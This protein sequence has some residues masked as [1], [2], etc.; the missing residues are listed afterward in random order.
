M[1]AMTRGTLLAAFAHPDD[2]AFGPGGTLALYVSRGYTVH[3][4]CAT[5]GEAGSLAPGMESTADL[6]TI[7]EMEL[8]C[9]VEALGLH[10]LHLLGY[11]D[12]GMP[13]SPDQDHPAAFIRAPFEEV[14]R[15]LVALIR[16]LRPD[17]VLTFDPYGGYGHPDH[18]YMHRAVREA[19]E[20]AGDPEVF[21]EHRAQGLQPHRPARLYYTTLPIGQLRPFLVVL[22]ILGVD[23]RRLG[24]NRDIDLEA[25]IRAAL[26]VT[27]RIDVRSVLDRKER[28]A[29]C[30]RS[31]GGGWMRQLPLPAFA[32]RILWGVET[33]HRAIPPFRLGEPIERDLFSQS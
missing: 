5:R 9:A 15:R 24:R 26:P 3:L 32:R 25:A 29:A 6:G 11:R 17:V 2:E 19:F 16:E 21:P 27:T 12:S 22:R 7:R 23:L 18:I 4:I 28:A 10:G 30:H 13:G 31:Q 1:A 33:F 8:R 14:V 20:R